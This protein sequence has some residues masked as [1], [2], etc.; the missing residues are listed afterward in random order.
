MKSLLELLKQGIDTI[1]A[2]IKDGNELKTSFVG[3][4]FQGV[5]GTVGVVKGVVN[6]VNNSKAVEVYRITGNVDEVARVLSLGTA[7]D[8]IVPSALKDVS[9]GLQNYLQKL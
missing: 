6:L 9:K 3:E 4:C 2:S 1:E 5:G 7:L 8:D